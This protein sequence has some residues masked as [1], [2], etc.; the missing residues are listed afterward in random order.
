MGYLRKQLVVID[1][2]KSL[3]ER[4]V[5]KEMEENIVER[6]SVIYI[7]VF[8]CGDKFDLSLLKNYVMS[9]FVE[10]LIE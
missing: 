2:L 7:D 8:V 10:K 1:C 3:L 5:K 9:I 6:N 4:Q